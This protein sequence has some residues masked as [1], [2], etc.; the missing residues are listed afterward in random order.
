MS[1]PKTIILEKITINDN[2]CKFFLFANS[3]LVLFIFFFT[4]FYN[5]NSWAVPTKILSY[6]RIL[7]CV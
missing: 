1:I 5:M 3:Y 7:F 2:L 6:R 4:H